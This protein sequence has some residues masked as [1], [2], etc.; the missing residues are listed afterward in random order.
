[1]SGLRPAQPNYTTLVT[2]QPRSVSELDALPD[3]PA[4]QLAALA[5]EIDAVEFAATRWVDS[6]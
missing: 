5:L 3:G 1:M 4:K 2:P 6:P